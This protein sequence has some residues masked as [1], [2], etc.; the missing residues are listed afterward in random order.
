MNHLSN[1]LV[2]DDMKENLELLQLLLKP[3]G[4][5][6][7][8]AETGE[9]ALQLIA[10]DPPDVILLDL[11]MPGM[12]GFE[13]CERVKQA[14]ETRHIPVIM[15]TGVIEHEANVRALE[16]GADDFVV[17][18]FD[19]L[20]LDARIRSAIR[21]KAL[22]D[23]LIG[24]QHDLEERIRERTIQLERIQYAAVFSLAKLAES[25]DPETGEHLERI[26]SY[27]RAIAEHLSEQPAYEDMVDSAFVDAIY[28]TS[29]LH[30]IGKVGIPDDILLKP[31]K[32]SA[33]EFDTMKTHS[34]IGGETLQAAYEEAGPNTM[35]DMGRDIAFYHHERWDGKGYPTGLKGEEIPLAARIVSLGDVYDALRSKRPYKEGF[36]H[37]KSKEII[38][39]GRGTQFDPAVIDAFVAREDEFV[40][41][42]ETL[43]D[44]T[45]AV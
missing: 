20:L 24:Y 42:K 35:L 37:E 39:E 38:M 21:S 3:K 43:D 36:S 2:V 8:T 31:G 28:F 7:Q 33:E 19:S 45:P 14:R 6:V 40:Q 4:Y 26:R 1:I 10:D 15:I 11:V 23:Q 17:R 41:I 32:L 27:A 44:V 25:R 30:D 16:A 34:N 9:K 29:P 12:N 13:V 5:T 22:Q 18:P